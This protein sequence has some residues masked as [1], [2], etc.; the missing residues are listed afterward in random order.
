MNTLGTTPTIRVVKEES[1]S[2]AHSFVAATLLTKGQLVKLNSN[3]TV[4]ALTA[5]TDM[6]IGMVTVGAAI[7][8]KATVQ[9]NF[10]AIVNAIA[11][12]S[13]TTGN[14]LAVNTHN[15]TSKKDEYKVA[16]PTN[17]VSAIAL[18]DASDNGE[19]VVGILRV[20]RIVEVPNE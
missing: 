19:L 14:A 5:L 20:P 6:P 13:V 17:V 3:G 11:E 4:G 1:Y 8:A 12:G 10:Q 15:A 18:S 2:I 9:T 16:V 7:G